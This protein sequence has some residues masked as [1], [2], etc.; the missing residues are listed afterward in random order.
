MVGASSCAEEHPLRRWLRYLGVLSGRGSRPVSLLITDQRRLRR[1]LSL[2]TRQRFASA[3]IS[4]S[5]RAPPWP[6]H[7]ETQTVSPR[8]NLSRKARLILFPTRE[9]SPLQSDSWASHSPT[10]A[11]VPPRTWTEKVSCLAESKYPH[12]LRQPV[13]GDRGPEVAAPRR[14]LAVARRHF[15]SAK[16]SG[17]QRAPL[18]QRQV[19]T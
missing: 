13:H 4:D 1:G 10:F 15:V 14:G 9:W 18:R 8:W 12:H 5:Q 7:L 17:F 11:A 2:V 6:T 3:R 19:E 16:V